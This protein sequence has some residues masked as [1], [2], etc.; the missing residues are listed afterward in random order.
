MKGLKIVYW[1]STILFAGF[2]GMSAIRNIM[3]TEDSVDLIVKQLGYPTYMLTFLGI[4]KLLGS[5]GILAPIPPRLKEWAYA[6]L[7]FDLVG[8]TYSNIAVAGF[9]PSIL[10]MLIFF[11]LIGL[12]YGSYHR[13]KATTAN[14]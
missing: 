3:I 2:M 4:A 10:G 11:A 13:M 9:Q 7:F 8:A 1:S 6:G 12:S 14:S 5:I